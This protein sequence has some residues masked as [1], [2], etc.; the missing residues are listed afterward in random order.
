MI[1]IQAALKRA[2]VAST[3]SLSPTSTT[4]RS[5][6]S[7]SSP[8]RSPPKQSPPR[9]KIQFRRNSDSSSEVEES[10]AESMIDPTQ[11]EG[12]RS[13]SRK[14]QTGTGVRTSAVQPG[15][16]P[17]AE[18]PPSAPPASPKKMSYFPSNSTLTEEE[19]LDADDGDD[20]QRDLPSP[21]PLPR[22]T[23]RPI[24]NGSDRRPTSS[25]STSTFQSST[26]AGR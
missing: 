17:M 16:S 1:K 20:S 12:K 23:A 13:P 5:V 26:F 10:M 15:S 7:Q 4:K 19:F 8:T 11:K 6:T 2:G 3:V 22:S 25:G 18:T 14:L 21:L 9:S 24:G